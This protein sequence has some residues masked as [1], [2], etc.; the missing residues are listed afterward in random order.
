MPGIGKKTE[1]TLRGIGI[2]T[3]GKLAALSPDTLKSYFG[4]TGRVL[5]RFARGI[6]DSRVELPPEAKSISRETTFSE[7]SHDRP[8]IEAALRYLSERVGKKLRERNKQART[9]TIKVRGADFS[10]A[11]RR[12]TLKTS[13]DAD[14]MI[15]KTGLELLDRE[16]RIQKQAIRLI[17]IGV[18]HLGETGRQLDMLDGTAA[19]LE[20]LNKAVDKIR[21]KYGFTS[22][23]TG[24]TYRLKDIF[25]EDD[26]RG[27]TLHTPSLS[28]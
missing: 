23:Q 11:T 22:I 1:A 28:R 3:I 6:D 9:I 4:A 2:D 14:Q 24:R 25:P 20:Q 27:Y 26:N 5:Y 17:G 10:T 8:L 21:R 12:R 19:K 13:T 7:D 18:S 15:F 16:L